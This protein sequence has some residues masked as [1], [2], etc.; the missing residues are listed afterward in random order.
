[1]WQMFL[2]EAGNNL[3]VYINNGK[4][5][6]VKHIFKNIFLPFLKRMEITWSPRR[7]CVRA[8]APPGKFVPRGNI[9]LKGLLPE[10]C[11]F[12]KSSERRLFPAC[13]DAGSRSCLPTRL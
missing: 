9:C 3:P 10:D 12:L 11:V 8:Q 6:L 2:I 5:R 13:V 1:M 7:L 4:G